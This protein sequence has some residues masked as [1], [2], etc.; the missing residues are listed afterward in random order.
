M[1]ER[2]GMPLICWS[3]FMATKS[4]LMH[5]LGRASGLCGASKHPGADRLE[6]DNR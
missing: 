5:V 1:M 4:G 6:E 2:N 3:G